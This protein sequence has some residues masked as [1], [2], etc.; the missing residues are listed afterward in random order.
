MANFPTWT[1]DY[2]S[3]SLAVLNLFIFDASICY[4]MVFPPLGNSDLVIVSV[5]IEFSSDSKWDAQFHHIACDY[6]CTYWEGLVIIWERCSM[7]SISKLSASAVANE[8]CEWFQV[9][10]DK[11][12][13]HIVS[14]RSSLTH[15]HGF[16]LLLLL[17]WFI[18]ITFFIYINRINHLNLK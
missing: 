3:H 9:V 11:Y 5:S 14:I 13:P 8:F 12:I 4:T 10:I 2:D 15:L 6:F 16:Q 17:P 1:P 18:E 7:G